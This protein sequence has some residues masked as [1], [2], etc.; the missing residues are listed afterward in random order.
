MIIMLA[1]C[2]AN[3]CLRSHVLG[4][5]YVDDVDIEPAPP[6]CQDPRKLLESAAPLLAWDDSN[7]HHPHATRR[8][9]PYNRRAL[10]AHGGIMDIQSTPLALSKVRQACS[11]ITPGACAVSR[12][13]TPESV[14]I[15]R[16]VVGVLFLLLWLDFV[17]PGR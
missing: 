9:Q 14:N 4:V 2:G 1:G 16:N 6:S 11:A 7:I 10:A 8:G 13:A 3:G 15:H 5:M 17:P 12:T